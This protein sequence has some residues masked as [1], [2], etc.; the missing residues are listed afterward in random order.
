MKKPEI[1]IANKSDAL[2]LLRRLIRTRL[3]SEQRA[4]L[5][6]LLDAF[7]ADIL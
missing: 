4:A 5:R 2:E 1:R 3:T 7:D 6:A